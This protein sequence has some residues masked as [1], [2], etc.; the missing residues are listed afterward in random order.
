MSARVAGSIA[1]PCSVLEHLPVDEPAEGPRGGRHAARQQ[2]R[3]LRPRARARTAR[4]R[5]RAG[6][7][8]AAAA[9]H[10]Q[11]H[12]DDVDSPATAR[13]CRRSAP[14]A[15][16]RSRQYTSSARTM[17]LRSRG[18]M[19]AADAGSTRCSMRCRNAAPRRSRDAL[20]PG[21]QR[22]S[23]AG[24]GKQPARQRAVVEAGA[25]DEDRQRARA[26]GCRESLRRRRARSAPRCS[27]RSGRRCR[28]GDAGCRGA[29]RAAPCRCRCRSRD[30]RP[31][32][33]S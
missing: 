16:G 17:R 29:R 10:P 25:A 7:A 8:R 4:R 33:R 2:R 24:P 18:L 1:T 22:A 9:R 6:A 12:G 15:A 30:R 31:S 14:S 21:A 13:R 19:R 32:S 23:A 26:R 11:R 20:Q 5:A 3:G 27:R 28:S